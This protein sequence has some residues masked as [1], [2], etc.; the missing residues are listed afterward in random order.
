MRLN[1]ISFRGT[2][3]KLTVAIAKFRRC[4]EN[5]PLMHAGHN[6]LRRS[7]QPRDYEG[8]EYYSKHLCKL[9]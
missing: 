5:R 7:G 4:L 2:F 9:E 1:Y 6:E 3:I 8:P